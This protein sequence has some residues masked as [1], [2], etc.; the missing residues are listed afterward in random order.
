MVAITLQTTSTILGIKCGCGFLFVRYKR[1]ICSQLVS[2]GAR[3][4]SSVQNQEG[5]LWEV[6]SVYLDSDFNPCHS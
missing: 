3:S 1:Q 4:L 2:L 6:V 5:R